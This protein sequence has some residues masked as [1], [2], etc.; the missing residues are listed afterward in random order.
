MN[1]IVIF[2]NGDLPDLDKA[3]ALLRHDDYIICAD[4][5]TRHASALDLKPALVIGDLDSADKSLLKKLR[6]EGVSIELFPRDKNETDLELAIQ[7]AVELDPH[8]I[9]ILAALGGRMDQTLANIALLSSSYLAGRSVRLDDGV[10]EIFFCRDQAQV[11]G[12]SGDTVSLLPWGGAVTGIHTENLKWQLNGEA[13]SPEKTR[14]ISNE[15]TAEMAAIRIQ[16]GLL[17][18]IHRRAS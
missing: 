12:R 13:L 14:G 11:R 4:G 7:R 15:M 3:R 2:A 9:L 5:G 16:S 17:L 18:I 6:D 10:E 1:R 8:E